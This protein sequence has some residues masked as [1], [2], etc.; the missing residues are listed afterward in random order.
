F[1]EFGIEFGSSLQLRS[2]AKSEKRVDRNLSIPYQAIPHISRVC[3]MKY[4]PTIAVLAGLLLN[5]CA[6]PVR[7]PSGEDRG[8]LTAAIA[9]RG[10]T[11]DQAREQESLVPTPASNFFKA[12]E[13]V[14][15]Y[16]FLAAYIGGPGV[17]SALGHGRGPPLPSSL[18]NPVVS[19]NSA[20]TA[21]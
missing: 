21:S 4:L 14:A 8:E 13:P 3:S 2:L 1:S 9:M 17:L 10:Q 11:A 19:P 16:S 15:G 18:P 6:A 7:I 5:G 12:A 20:P